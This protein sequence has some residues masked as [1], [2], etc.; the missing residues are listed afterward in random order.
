MSTKHSHSHEEHGDKAPHSYDV[1]IVGGGISGL[2]TATFLAEKGLKVV[3]LEKQP[4]VGGKPISFLNNCF[5]APPPNLPLSSIEKPFIPKPTPFIVLPGEH[6][7][8]S[9]PANYVNL[10]AIMARIPHPDGGFVLDKLTDVLVTAPYN[11]PQISL[12]QPLNYIKARAE[13]VF[14][15]LALILPYIVSQPRA[16]QLFEGD[17]LKDLLV[18]PKRS[19]E[20]QETFFKISGVFVGFQPETVGAY[21]MCNCLLNYRFATDGG[22]ATFALPTSMAWLN[23]WRTYLEKLGVEFHTSTEVTKFNFDVSRSE[24]VAVN[25]IEYTANQVASVTT[26]DGQEF[27]GK[28]IVSAIP[29]D[30]LRE[31]FYANPVY[32]TYD[33]NLWQ[34]DKLLTRSMTGVQLFFDSLIE[35]FDKQVIYGI[36]VPHPWELSFVQQNTYW[37]QPLPSDWAPKGAAIVTVYITKTYAPGVIFNKSYVSCTYDEIAT[38]IFTAVETELKRRGFKIPGRVGFAI[39]NT[40]YVNKYKVL[41]NNRIFV[42]TP[43]SWYDRPLPETCLF[44]NFYMTGDYTLTDLTYSASTMESAT[45]AGM[46]TSGAIL[47]QFNLEPTLVQPTP[48]QWYFQLLRWIDSILFRFHIPNPLYLI[49]LFIG[50][51]LDSTS[52][53]PADPFIISYGNYK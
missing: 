17:S 51:Y 25:T 43:N 19:K 18:Y 34:L 24:D 31:I 41:D 1:V 15:I 49:Y 7:F 12:A 44:N 23:P 21:E 46:K 9:Y 42:P 14:V 26:K 40:T 3:I 36:M 22:R 33:Q 27:A 10:R 6:G 5:N 20:I 47:K 39:D 8:R 37:E 50:R 38:E 45:E 35:G 28:Y 13:T 2:V 16:L 48:I 52:V 29:S 30:R 4:E 32:Y 11:L 53:S